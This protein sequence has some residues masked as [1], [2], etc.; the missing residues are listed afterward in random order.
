MYG[1][2]DDLGNVEFFYRIREFS[3]LLWK[4]YQ[5]YGYV[6]PTK[7]SKRIIVE[8]PSAN[9]V[10]NYCMQW[11]ETEEALT[12][13][14]DICVMLEQRNSLTKP[15]LYTYDAL[16]LD[17]HRSEAALLPRIKALM[18]GAVIGEAVYPTRMYKGKNYNDLMQV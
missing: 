3:Q 9:K 11:L 13:V 1:M 15:I 8:D 7:N 5:T 12:R 16:L 17:L 10:F 14:N 18:E 2:T 6:I 4:E